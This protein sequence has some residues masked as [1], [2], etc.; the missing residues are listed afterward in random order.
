MDA[1]PFWLLFLILLIVVLGAVE[2]GHRWGEYA[3]RRSEDEKESPVGVI[4]G[5]I[6]ALLAFMMAF[7]FGIVSDRYDARK[8]LVRDQS[9]AIGTAYLRADFLAEPGQ[10]TSK[11]LYLE[12]VNASILA[13][14]ANSVAIA[15]EM[16]QRGNE[17][18][19]QLWDIAV[20]NGRLDMNS[21]IGALYVEALN[22]SIDI[23]ANRVT[24][25]IHARVPGPIWIMLGLLLILAMVGI[26]YQT[27]IA[28]SRRSWAAV[29]LAVSFT[30][31][32]SLILI[33]DRPEN[34]ILTVPQ[35]PLESLRA[36]IE[37]DLLE[38]D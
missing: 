32:I 23:M 13:A 5:T 26:G 15:Q 6:L 33:L 29:M 30:I 10:Q 25:G 19:A 17:I 35:Q 34:G 16:V 18:N 7:T 20:V 28:A 3:H 12:I 9:N 24:L 31:V 37:A 21:D 14:E 1:V 4:S 36:S 27:G 11:E 2:I 8:A 22:E 38:S